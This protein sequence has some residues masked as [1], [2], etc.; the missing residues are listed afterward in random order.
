M[1][2]KKSEPFSRVILFPAGRVHP[3]NSGRGD[4]VL[5]VDGRLRDHRSQGPPVGLVGRPEV[6]LGHCQRR[7]AALQDEGSCPGVYHYQLPALILN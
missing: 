4:Q 1:G 6:R 5:L 7:A 3:N 2:E